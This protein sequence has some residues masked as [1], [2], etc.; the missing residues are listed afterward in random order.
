MKAFVNK[1]RF[2]DFLEKIPVKVI[3]NDEAALVGAAHC[4]IVL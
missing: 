1:G 3:L 2:K 4:A